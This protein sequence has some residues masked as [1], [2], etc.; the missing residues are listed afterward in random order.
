MNKPHHNETPGIIASDVSTTGVS[1]KRKRKPPTKNYKYEGDGL[2]EILDAQSDLGRLVR[3][4]RIEGGIDGPF[5]TTKLL[6]HILTKERIKNELQRPEY[7]LNES[8][9]DVY[10]DQIHPESERSSPQVYLKIFALLVLVERHLDI[11]NFIAE[12]FCDQMLPIAIDDLDVYCLND[13]EKN[14][15]CFNGWKIT[16]KENFELNQW[17][18]DTPYFGT[19][20]DQSLIEIHLWPDT[21]KP[22]RTTPNHGD[23]PE[24]ET[25]DN[26]GAYGIVARSDI[27]PT[28][29][30]YDKLLIGINLDSTTFAIKTMVRMDENTMKTFKTEWDMLKRFSGRAHPHLVTALSAFRQDGK[31]SFIF[32]NASCALD[33]YMVA[34]NPPKNRT[35]V[36]WF[37]SQMCGL[38]GALDTI[39][40]PKHLHLEQGVIR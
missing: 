38:M 8:Q 39:H 13:Q 32:P 29:H 24:L 28:A 4:Y 26:E 5:W 6:R 22:W 27:H 9:V 7:G 17:K 16:E 33:Q 21:R 2:V 12:K 15:G 40:D 19:A 10:V 31:L 20:K 34:S 37:S 25:E 11:S 35:G 14:I 30:S 3:C 23:K 18:V 1:T 36:L